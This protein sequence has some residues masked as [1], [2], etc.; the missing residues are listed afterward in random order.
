MIRAM[1]LVDIKF[2]ND[3]YIDYLTQRRIFSSLNKKERKQIIDYIVYKYNFLDYQVC[4]LTILTPI[5]MMLTPLK[6]AGLSKSSLCLLAN[7]QQRSCKDITFSFS[8]TLLGER[9][10]VMS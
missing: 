10:C 7:R 4:I 3:E 1:R 9:F 2:G 5:L 6:R 8:S